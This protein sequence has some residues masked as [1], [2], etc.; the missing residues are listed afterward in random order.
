MVEPAFRVRLVTD[1]AIAA[2]VADRVY[3]NIRPA[4]ERRPCLVLTRVSTFFARRF[5]GDSSTTKG[6][7]QVDVFGESYQEVKE[8]AAKVRGR[9]DGF[10]GTVAGTRFFYIEVEDER[11]VPAAPL[12]GRA[13]PLYAVS[14]DARFLFAG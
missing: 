13:T 3:H 7:M 9:L 12:A 4:D 5:G 8:L 11:D 14:I 10:T 2:V 1:P 6:R